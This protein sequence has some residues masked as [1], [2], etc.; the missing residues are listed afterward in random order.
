MVLEGDRDIVD[1][2]GMPQ[3]SKLRR[4]QMV[5]DQELKKDFFYEL[6]RRDRKFG[7]K[8]HSL[9]FQNIEFAVMIDKEIL[10]ENKFLGYTFDK[11]SKF[12]HQ[13]E[14]L[15]DQATMYEN[16]HY[17]ITSFSCEVSFRG[18]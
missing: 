10:T 2:F 6:Y 9:G 15:L 18:D 11:S 7:Q 17:Q 8:L 14:L 4:F 12:S 5:V 16:Q 13:Y 3:K 1:Q